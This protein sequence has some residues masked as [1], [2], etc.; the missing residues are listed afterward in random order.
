[1]TLSS[2]G[3]AQTQL[4]YFSI[5]EVF[6]VFTNGDRKCSDIISTQEGSISFRV[7]KSTINSQVDDYTDLKWLILINFIEQT[8]Q[9]SGDGAISWKPFVPVT[10][11]FY[12]SPV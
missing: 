9:M 7:I 11:C 3:T 10:L 8:A 4:F 1:M 12:R 5:N 6:V 2:S